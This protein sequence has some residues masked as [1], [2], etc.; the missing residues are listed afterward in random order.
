MKNIIFLLTIVL[1]SIMQ[2]NCYANDKNLKN[3]LTKQSLKELYQPNLLYPSN[4]IKIQLLTDDKIS[5]FKN[6][7]VTFRLLQTVDN[8]PISI[9]SIEPIH[10]PRLH[11]YLI[12]NSFTDYHHLYP[13]PLTSKDQL[14]FSFVPK[15]NEPYNLWI[16]MKVI[17]TKQ[18]EYVYQ[19]LNTNSTNYNDPSNNETLLANAG[20]YS[21]KLLFSE[22]LRIG[23]LINGK[24][25]IHK[26]NNI[27][28]SPKLTKINYEL[29]NI[30]GFYYKQNSIFHLHTTNF[31]N[32]TT[33]Q[34]W[35][36]QWVPEYQDIVKMFFE[37]KIHDQTFKIPF[38]IS[39]K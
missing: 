16:T 29:L 26:Q 12:N 30:I 3:E 2:T 39:I 18:E 6:K 25:I 13:V 37:F 10:G 27:Y 32:S 31:I 4:S 19:K 22:P 28:K 5:S 7:E 1:L 36:F 14:Y 24:V 21:F 20:D 38:T 17:S 15:T 23:H 9:N 8:L 35:N 11:A 34:T 33:E